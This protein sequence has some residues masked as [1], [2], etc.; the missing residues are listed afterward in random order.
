MGDARL[1]VRHLARPVRVERP[2]DRERQAVLV[3]RGAAVDLAGQLR[4]AVRRTWRRAARQVL[5]GR[6]ELLGA[7]EHHARRHVGEAL[8]ALL[9]RCAEDGVV[10]R[11][12]GLRQRERELVEVRDPADDRGQV[13]DVRAAADRASRLRRRR[14]G[15]RCGSRRPRA[16]SPAPAAGRTRGSRSRDRRSSRRTTAA[17][18]V[19]APPVTRTRL[20]C[21]ARRSRSRR[22]RPAPRRARST[23]RRRRQSGFAALGDRG[24]R[25][26]RSNALW[27]VATITTSASVDRLLERRGRR[28]ARAGRGPRRR[29]ARARAAGSACARASR[30][31]RRC[32]A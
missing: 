27:L 32:R 28:G 31:R 5:L 15:R 12:V 22:R 7:L 16:S 21:A 14:A 3:V 17:P 30:A 8:D 26:G 23:G 1:G 11:V 10:E 24:Q 6:R 13:D 18:I 9:D 25:V 20:T 2:A 4:P 19:P 29:R